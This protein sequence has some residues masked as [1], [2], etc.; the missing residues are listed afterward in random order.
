[1]QAFWERRMDYLESDLDIRFLT[2]HSP[3]QSA[4][5]RRSGHDDMRIRRD[6]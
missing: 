3:Y 2:M 4:A 6:D 5:R 1:M